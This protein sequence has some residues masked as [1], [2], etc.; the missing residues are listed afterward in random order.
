MNEQETK[1]RIAK[2][3]CR[4]CEFDDTKVN[5]DCS[6]GEWDCIE[7]H[8]TP[9]RIATEV[10][11]EIYDTILAPLV[12][13]NERMKKFCIDKQVELD[14]V[15]DELVLCKEEQLKGFNSA[16][17]DSLNVHMLAQLKKDYD[18]IKQKYDI[19][20]ASLD[21]SR[22]ENNETC[23][24]YLKLEAEY[25][26]ERKL[27][28]LDFEALK[29]SVWDALGDIPDGSYYLVVEKMQ[30]LRERVNTAIRRN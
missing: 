21:C 26:D 20:V 23:K 5:E 13:E 28:N 11:S 18:D 1:L 15:R 27:H 8:D 19:A 4:A 22:A 24:R 25:K 30:Q 17:F 7:N 12:A 14:K 16:V 9:C 29:L 2:A 6:Y 10:A 3:S